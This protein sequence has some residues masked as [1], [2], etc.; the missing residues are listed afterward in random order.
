MTRTLAVGLAVLAY[1]PTLAGQSQ[2]PPEAPRVWV[3]FSADIRIT[4]ANGKEAWG[5]RL[6]DE[7]GCVRDEMVHPQRVSTDGG[8]ARRPPR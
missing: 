4:F 5:R 7:H 1:C 6:Q 3:A 2:S 8:R